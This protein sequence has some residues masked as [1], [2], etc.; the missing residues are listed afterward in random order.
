MGVPVTPLKDEQTQVSKPTTETVKP[1]EEHNALNDV[2]TALNASNDLYKGVKE[3]VEDAEKDTTVD[4]AP[5]STGTITRIIVSIA[6]L[7]NLVFYASGSARHLDENAI[8]V[9]ATTIA[10]ILNTAWV[11]WKNNDVSRK[12]RKRAKL[13]KEKNASK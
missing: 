7:A 1:T 6:V 5:I 3:L 9:G 10:P 4:S 12:A 2:G 11:F 8:Y 13:L